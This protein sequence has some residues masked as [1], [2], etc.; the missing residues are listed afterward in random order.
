M[1]GII[2]MS[3]PYQMI[4]CWNQLDHKTC[5]SISNDERL[6]SNQICEDIIQ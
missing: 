4:D 3:K 6:H 5:E 1:G 2:R